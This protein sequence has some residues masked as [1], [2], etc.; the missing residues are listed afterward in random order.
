MDNI[1]SA[2]GLKIA[3]HRL[4]VEQAEKWQLLKNQ[5]L[6]TVEIFKP[7]NLLKNAAKGF[8]SSPHLMDHMLDTVVGLA[9]GL[10][11]RKLI[12]GSS[13][14]IIRKILGSVMQLGI[15]TIAAKNSDSIQSF[16]RFVFQ[17][18]FLKNVQNTQKR[19]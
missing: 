9:T 2:D 18:V 19:G 10:V 3:I 14:S 5:S 12:V 8:L 13:F 11:T 16:G 6:Q 4:E 15:T 7:A 1:T 17:K